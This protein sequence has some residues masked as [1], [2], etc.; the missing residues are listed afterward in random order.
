MTG[1]AQQGLHLA[2]PILALDLDQRL[3]FTQV[4]GVAQGVQHLSYPLILS[5]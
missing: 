1:S 4:M 2:R 5:L 3:E